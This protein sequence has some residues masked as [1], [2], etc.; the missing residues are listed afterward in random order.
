MDK[1][2]AEVGSPSFWQW[3]SALPVTEDAAQPGTRKDP[4]Q[5]RL[6]I[7]L[8]S[9][10][11]SICS[12]PGACRHETVLRTPAHSAMLPALDVAGSMSHRVERGHDRMYLS[13]VSSGL[14][15][16]AF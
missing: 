7:E 10:A 15:Y 4:I 8:A 2:I 16:T 14:S 12:G 13:S 3:L 6:S 9:L 11:S 5:G 1:A